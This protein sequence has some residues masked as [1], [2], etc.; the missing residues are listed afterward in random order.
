MILL[1]TIVPNPQASPPSGSMA[2]NVTSE[3]VIAQLL[4][5]L[6][7]GFSWTGPGAVGAISMQGSND[8][9]ENADGS[10]NNPGTWSTLTVNYQGSPT[11]SI[12][13]SGASGN[14]IIDLGM[15]GIYAL[16][17]V[18]TRTSGSGTLTSICCGKG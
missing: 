4:P 16:R 8:Y 3:T 1:T 13:I 2:S 17:L 5:V 7:F 14:G 18:Y 9:S 6:S 15:T 11:S 12:A 10:V